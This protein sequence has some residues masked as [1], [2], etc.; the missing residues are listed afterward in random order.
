MKN[1]SQPLKSGCIE[2]TNSYEQEVRIK[3]RISLF[4]VDDARGFNLF[5]HFLCPL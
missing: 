5:E 1:F 4:V 3:A 2:R